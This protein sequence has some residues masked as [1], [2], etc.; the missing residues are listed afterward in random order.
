MINRLYEEH[1]HKLYNPDLKFRFLNEVYPDNQQTQQTIVFN[2]IKSARV[3]K[4]YDK[5]LCTF[6]IEEINELVESLGYST[7]STIRSAL[8]FF[9]IYVDWCIEN[10]IRGDYE[11][12]V[13]DISIFI[14]TQN[15]S[16]FTSK[17][18]NKNRYVTKQEIYNAV[19]YLVNPID[20]AL[21]LGIYEGIFGEELYEIRSLKKEGNINFETNEVILE[22]K[23]GTTRT[24]TIS[25]KLLNIFKKAIVQETYELGNGESM[26]IQTKQLINSTYII[27]PVVRKNNIADEIIEYGAVINKFINIKKYTGLNFITPQSVFDSGM[28]NRTLEIA[29]EQGLTE[30]DNTTF[31]YLKRPDEYNISTIQL[32]NFKKKYKLATSLKKFD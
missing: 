8:S 16:K 28:I 2:F 10:S 20:Q 6:N 26:R 5:D 25:D 15:L 11:T 31:R 14:S 17:I 4:M 7:E 19:D 21:L 23:D 27:R 1:S 12:G 18:K 9:S 24:K 13:N 30:P 22:N 29:K 3:E 32:H